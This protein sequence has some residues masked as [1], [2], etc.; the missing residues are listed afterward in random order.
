MKKAAIIGS[1]DMAI[2]ICSYL[3]S[4]GY[5]ITGYFDDYLKAGTYVFKGSVLGSV[6]EITSFRE[7]FDEVFIGVGYKYLKE[8]SS[9]ADYL[10]DNKIKTGKFIHNTAYYHDS[11][12][13]KSG[14]FILPKCTID[15]SVRIGRNVFMNPNCCVS[16]DSEIGDET[17]LGPG[18]VVSGKSK[19][20]K[21]CFLG[22]GS[23]IKDNIVICD[24]VII[25]AG[26]VVVK[27][28]KEEGVYFGV[29]AKKKNN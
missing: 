16:H 19:I 26:A 2:H 9:I 8:K 7:K 22:A 6:K 20:G 27:D 5:K 24:N 28:I 10:E 13:L 12:E 3:L 1:S 21:R 17:F 14:V 29:P 11:S 15:K 18:V 25:G 23:T 4:D